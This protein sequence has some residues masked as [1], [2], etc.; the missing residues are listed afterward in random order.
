MFYASN[1][2]TLSTFSEL[3]RKF[4]LLLCYKLN[5]FRPPRVN[6]FDSCALLFGS[7]SRFIPSDKMVLCGYWKTLLS[8]SSSMLHIGLKFLYCVMDSV[9]VFIII[10]GIILIV[11]SNTC[12]SIIALVDETVLFYRLLTIG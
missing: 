3:L 4:T 10:I 6:L 12:V 11:F 5:R 2:M 9:V 7:Y 1:V 8:G